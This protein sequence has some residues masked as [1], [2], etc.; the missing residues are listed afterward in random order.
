ME[1]SPE[2]NIRCALAGKRISQLEEKSVEIIQCERRNAQLKNCW[3]CQYSIF[4][5]E[6]NNQTGDQRQRKPTRPSRHLQNISSNN[7]RMHVPLTCTWNILQDHYL[8]GRK[9]SLKIFKRTE[10]IQNAF[11]Q[12]GIKL[13]INNRMKSYCFHPGYFFFASHRGMLPTYSHPWKYSS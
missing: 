13:I 6:Q 10:I 12:N 1:Y 7:S 9:T 5:N 2:L 11:D 3:R 4:N 8:L